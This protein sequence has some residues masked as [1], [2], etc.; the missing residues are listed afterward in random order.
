MVLSLSLQRLREAP[1]NSYFYRSLVPQA[2]FILRI[3]PVTVIKSSGPS[4]HGFSLLINTHLDLTLQQ[5][6]AGVNLLEIE[7]S[8]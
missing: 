7:N 8:F 1:L 5:L 4:N 2:R 3:R 6:M